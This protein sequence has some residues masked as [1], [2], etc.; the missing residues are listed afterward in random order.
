MVIKI[1][2]DFE[3][4][5]NIKEDDVT[6][7]VEARSSDRKIIVKSSK[8]PAHKDQKDLLSLLMTNPH[9]G[10]V[11]PL[12]VH[13]DVDGRLVEVY[14]FVSFPTLFGMTRFG[15]FL[16]TDTVLSIMGG[17]CSSLDYLHNAG[18][19]HHDIR[20]PNLFVDMSPNLGIMLFDYNISRRP[21]TTDCKIRNFHRDAA[22]EYFLNNHEINF[23]YDIYQ[24]GKLMVALMSSPYFKDES[25]KFLRVG[26]KAISK[27]PKNRYQNASQ[28]LI[29]LNEAKKV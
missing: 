25:G 12:D 9:P 14:D 3:V 24:A 4:V 22:P 1:S 20:K 19:I 10:L 15:D 11:V 5:R 7:V 6:K 23:S 17:L 13:E 28:M 2:L 8:V 27:D 18:F 29:A 26:F 21:Y 16:S